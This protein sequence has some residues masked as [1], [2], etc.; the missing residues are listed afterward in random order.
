MADLTRERVLIAG[1]V[2]HRGGWLSRAAG[3]EAS[4]P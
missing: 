1:P 2:T 4:R 3:G